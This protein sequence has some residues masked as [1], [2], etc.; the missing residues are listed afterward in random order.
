M[1]QS[2]LAALLAGSIALANAT[3]ALGQPMC[4]P[5]LVIKEAQLSAMLPPSLARKWTAA[6]SVDASSCTTTSGHFVIGFARLKENAPDIVFHETFVWKPDSVTV[7][8]DFW[9][10]EAV[11][12]YW[13]GDTD[14]CPCRD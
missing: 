7:S 5:A 1:Y 11:E 2:S 12:H 13:L 10:D 4:K 8:V 3:Q 6:I 9:A 14:A